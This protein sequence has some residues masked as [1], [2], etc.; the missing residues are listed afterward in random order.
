MPGPSTH[1][2]DALKGVLVQQSALL[3][4]LLQ[5]EDEPGAGH[6]VGVELVGW[7]RLKVFLL[8]GRHKA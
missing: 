2:H 1:P 3:G 7:D 4:G 6:P 5:S 8:A